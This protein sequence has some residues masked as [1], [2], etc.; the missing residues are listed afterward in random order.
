MHRHY[1][2]LQFALKFASKVAWVKKLQPF[3]KK[4]DFG[5][6]KS[7]EMETGLETSWILLSFVSKLPEITQVK[8]LSRYISYK[9]SYRQISEKLH[10]L[11][12]K[13]GDPF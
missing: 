13:F 8:I 10:F 5:I 9:Q 6:S 12:K 2:K 4:S 1:D 7:S 11:Q 3:E